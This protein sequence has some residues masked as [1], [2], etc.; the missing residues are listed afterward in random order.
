MFQG[1]FLKKF[2][3][4]GG[5]LGILAASLVLTKKVSFRIAI[6]QEMSTQPEEMSADWWG[7]MVGTALF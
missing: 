7:M 3:E 5:I 4:I 2:Q 1:L 6:L